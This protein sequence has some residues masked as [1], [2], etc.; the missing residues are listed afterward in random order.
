MNNQLK[1]RLDLLL[2]DLKNDFALIAKKKKDDEWKRDHYRY[3]FTVHTQ[4]IYE[5]LNTSI[6][7]EPQT[8]IQTSTKKE[9]ISLRDYLNSMIGS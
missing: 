5:M 9:I 1:P 8:Q 7:E 6:T 4:R 3:T 2:E